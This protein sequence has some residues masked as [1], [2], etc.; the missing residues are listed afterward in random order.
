MRPMAT[1]VR[2]VGNFKTS[3]REVVTTDLKSGDRL[4]YVFPA[5]ASPDNASPFGIAHGFT[6]SD[7]TWTARGRW[8]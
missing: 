5:D 3:R 6:F 2:P 8:R 1:L 7:G 4:A